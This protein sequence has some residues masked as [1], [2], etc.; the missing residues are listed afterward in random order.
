MVAIMAYPRFRWSGK[1]MSNS[2]MMR[3]NL[4]LP[5]PSS[6]VTPHRDLPASRRAMILSAMSRSSWL[7]SAFAFAF[8]FAGL[9]GFGGLKNLN[10]PRAATPPKSGLGFT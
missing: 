3:V 8:T 10:P 5:M 4:Q 6:K 2:A 9:S 7:G 1:L